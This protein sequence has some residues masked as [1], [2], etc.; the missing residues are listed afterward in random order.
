MRFGNARSKTNLVLVCFLLLG[1]SATAGDVKS[2]YE[3]MQSAAAEYRSG[4]PDAAIA[5]LREY[6][7]TAADD[8]TAR[9]E[10]ARYL[11]FSK[12]YPEARQQYQEVLRRDA[13]NIPA[14]LGIAKI[15]SW[16]GDFPAALELYDK[17]LTRSPQFYDA[18]VG[19]AFTL[20]WMG[21]KEQ[22][23]EIFR[24]AAR[25]HPNDAEIRDALK[26]IGIAAPVPSEPTAAAPA[27]TRAEPIIRARSQR[28]PLHSSPA[29][30]PRQLTPPPI[31]SFPEPV[32]PAAA[33][34]PD[35]FPPAATALVVSIA[36]VMCGALVFLWRNHTHAAVESA[37]PVPASQPLMPTPPTRA[38]T[39]FIADANASALEFQRTVFVSASCEVICA[40]DPQEALAALRQ[41]R[42]DHVVLDAQMHE[43]VAFIRQNL[44]SLAERMLLTA[45]N[46]D[47]AQRA[48]QITG[49]R[50][51]AKP[52]RMADLIAST[53]GISKPESKILE[54]AVR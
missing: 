14:T 10:L 33:L 13:Q 23:A 9:V 45:A 2:H 46:S 11:A 36:F 4:T 42:F 47:D 51:I 26:E 12:R 18:R 24:W 20:L 7:E 49:L 34:G 30:S 32:A 29:T 1:I 3:A 50:C 37:P 6:L 43:V 21:E 8:V 5:T 15:H 27:L 31:S 52:L 35:R 40:A 17:I 38:L 41:H 48:K 16:E 25:V 53:V 22:A 39:V 28:S 54:F 44:P 19:K